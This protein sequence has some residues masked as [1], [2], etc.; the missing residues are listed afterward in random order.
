MDGKP[1]RALRQ[2]SGLQ[3]QSK[4]GQAMRQPEVDPVSEKHHELISE[5][6]VG[7]LG[8]GVVTVSRHPVL[9][10]AVDF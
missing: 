6:L 10:K 7:G 3:C 1:T 5:F 4:G 8:E 9:D 2:P